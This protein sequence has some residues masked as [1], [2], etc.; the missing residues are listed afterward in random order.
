MVLHWR[1]APEPYRRVPL[2][3]DWTRAFA[4]DE[5]GYMHVL[6][7]RDGERLVG[8]VIN[9]VISPVMHNSSKWSF[10]EG[11]FLLPEY[12]EG[13]NGYN[14]IKKNDRG[15]KMLGVNVIKFYFPVNT[16]EVLLRR[17]KYEFLEAGAF[18]FLGD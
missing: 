2:D 11:I 13:W 15:M 9:H 12:R 17:L 5:M 1:G 10:V 16:F 18:K 4:T 3:I 7:A 14:L 8:Y 6:T